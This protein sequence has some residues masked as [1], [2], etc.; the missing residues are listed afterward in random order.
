MAERPISVNSLMSNLERL[1]GER[2]APRWAQVVLG[3]RWSFGAGDP[4]DELAEYALPEP[5]LLELLRARAGLA[6]RARRG[7]D[8]D[9]LADH[10]AAGGAAVVAVDS[11]DLPYRPAYGRVH[12]GRT[13]IVRPD[14]ADRAAVR[15]EDLWHPASTGGLPLAVLQAAR[16]SAVPLDPVREPVFAGVPLAGAWWTVERVP[17]PPPDLTGW[18]AARLSDLH[19]DAAGPP[20]SGCV[21]A[22]R[23]AELAAG[24][25]GSPS[26][27]LRRAAS[28]RLRAELGSRA[29]MVALLRFAGQSFGDALL[30]SE[31]ERY[32]G[33][34]HAL[35]DARDLLIKSLALP[36]PQY[37]RL[38]GAS[39]ERAARAEQRLAAVLEPYRA[40]LAAHRVEAG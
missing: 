32:V 15:F 16:W 9:G 38:I 36:R 8:E 5:G 33:G 13:I 1:A 3:V 25:H 12:S 24:L 4:A 11:H 23:L 14:P 20:G 30:L 35:A 28:L 31:L 22:E 2:T 39:L 29:Y 19:R 7:R 6:V 27:E 21:P 26:W 34:L 10:L 40:E 37:G 18:L 17:A